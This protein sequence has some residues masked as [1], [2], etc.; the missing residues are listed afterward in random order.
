MAEEYGNSDNVNT[1]RAVFASN[2]ELPFGKG[3]KGFAGVLGKG[4]QANGILT[5]P[6]GFP[7][8]G[9]QFGGAGQYRRPRPS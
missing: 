9:H 3:L 4:W 8:H 6:T 1:Q 7:S 2:Y 5:R